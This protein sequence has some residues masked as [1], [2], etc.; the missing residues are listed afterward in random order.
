LIIKN[1]PK[2]L[3]EERMREHFQKSGDFV[4]TDVKIMRKG[5][6]SRQFGFVG[7]KNDRHAK[8]AKKFFHATYIDTSKIEIDFAR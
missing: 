3:T 2:H 5:A 6:K 4:V 7:F 8:S 1:L